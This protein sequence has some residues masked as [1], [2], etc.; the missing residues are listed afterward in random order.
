MG[1]AGAVSEPAPA[2]LNLFLRV[3]GRRE[4]GYHDIRSLIVPLTLADG[5]QARRAERLLLT[6]VGEC[7]AD[8]PR[9]EDNLVVRAARAL[10]EAEGR[11][12]AAE[13]LLTKQ[14]PVAAG[15]GGGSADAAAALRALARL[16]GVE[17][18]PDRLREV[19]A[20]IGS[21]VPALLEVRPALVRGRGDIVEPTESPRTWWV[22][23]TQPFGVRAADAYRWWDEDGGQAGPD[24]EP[25]L[26]AIRSGELERA[27]SL[28]SNDLEGPVAARH[29][30]VRA[31]KNGLL[32]AGALGAIMVGSGPSVAG[33]VR[34]GFHA[35]EVAAATGGFV[36]ASL[37]RG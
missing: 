10:A 8:V 17:G 5:V 24:P 13:L 29:A 1:E 35:E 22:L 28:L 18:R 34:S 33:L 15:L 11:E 32:E 30:E 16:W 14:I 20:G 12:P 36:V 26:T 6:V 3:L 9:R 37:H 31:A 27:G 19:A 25:M 4:D 7:A 2:K 21:D 23:L